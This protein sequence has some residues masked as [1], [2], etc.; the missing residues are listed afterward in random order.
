MLSLKTDLPEDRI[1]VSTFS[2]HFKFM[3]IIHFTNIQ[4]NYITSADFTFF[5]LKSQFNLP[6]SPG[7]KYTNL[8]M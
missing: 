3:D 8:L 4:Y 2:I 7:Q 1:Q 5:T 6:C